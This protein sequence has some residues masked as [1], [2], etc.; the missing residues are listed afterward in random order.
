METKTISNRMLSL[1]VLYDMHTKYLLNALD[2]ISDQDAHNRLNTK[3]NHVAWLTGS[4][5]QERFEGVKKFGSESQRDLKQEADELFKDHKGIQD[6]INYPPLANFK[7]DLDKI[8]P[9]L[10]EALVNVND[11]KLDEQ[12]E[13]MPGMKMTYYELITFMTYRE[14]SIIGQIALLRRLLGYEGMKYM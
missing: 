7:K 10:R 12:F 4:F 14:A 8:S 1:V 11:E 5:V 13:M 6:N 3:A 2:G 9:L